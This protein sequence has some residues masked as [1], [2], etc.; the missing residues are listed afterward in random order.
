MA[1]KAKGAKIS[2]G[3]NTNLNGVYIGCRKEVTIG[4]NCRIA[5]GV[6]IIDYNGHEVNSVNRTRGVDTPK[7]IVIGDNVWIATN[8]IILK[9]TII[10]DNSVVAANSV[11]KGKF[12]ENTIIQG[13]PAQIVGKLNLKC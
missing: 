12:G 10:G 6:V 13:N 2:I 4:K 8:A 1:V 5:A 11:V 9:G 3:D 7:P